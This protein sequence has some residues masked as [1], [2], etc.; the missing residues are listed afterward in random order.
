MSTLTV[1]YV[2]DTSSVVAALTQ[3]APPRGAQ[4][5]ADLAG[6]G[7]RLRGFD[8][9]DMT[10][11]ADRL[12]LAV[13]D[14]DPG[15]LTDPRAFYVEPTQQNPDKLKLTPIQVPAG[16]LGLALNAAGVTISRPITGTAM[17]ALV[18]LEKADSP[19]RDPVVVTGAFGASSAQI[20]LPIALDSGNWNAGLFV[21]RLRPVATG[22]KVP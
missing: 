13:V 4:S 1:L 16:H 20:T 3:A 14:A 5:A 15:V 11:A 18:I 7:L 10:L 9:I 12:A 19:K 17:Q 22:A 8:G 2:H 6:S 21:S